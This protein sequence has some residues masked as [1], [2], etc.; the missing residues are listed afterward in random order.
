M[1][2]P[3]AGGDVHAA[4][5]DARSDRFLW[6]HRQSSLRLGA[7]MVEAVDALR[8]VV[9]D[10]VP[11]FGDAWL[12]WILILH[13][14]LDDGEVPPRYRAALVAAPDLVIRRRPC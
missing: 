7:D 12:F 10:P 3:L 1:P 6:L 13:D 14:L 8:T 2:L 4:D 9:R 11:R 5:Y